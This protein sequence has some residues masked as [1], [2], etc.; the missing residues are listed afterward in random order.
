MT[1][2]SKSAQAFE[3][4]FIGKRKSSMA[5]DVEARLSGLNERSPA[6]PF[7]GPPIDEGARR[8]IER[9]L[10]ILPIFEFISLIRR[11]NALLPFA[12][13]RQGST[14][15]TFC[16]TAVDDP[17]DVPTDHRCI[18]AKIPHP[19]YSRVYEA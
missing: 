18:N 9:A 14:L 4:P 5:P 17:P 7:D 10:N 19:R 1:L 12:M 2:M 15:I 13:R 11:A 3:P 8:G 16:G 6:N